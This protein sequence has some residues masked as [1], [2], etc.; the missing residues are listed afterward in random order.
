MI[1]AMDNSFLCLL[2]YPNAGLPTDPTTNAPVKEAKERIET[3]LKKHLDNEDRVIVPSPSLAELAVIVEDLEK[4]VKIIKKSRFMKIA[5]FDAR[6]AQEWGEI[7]REARVQGDKKSG[8][9][10]S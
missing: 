1:V 10:A 7:A 2:F 9:Q 8:A 5:D 4:V 3:L 6:C